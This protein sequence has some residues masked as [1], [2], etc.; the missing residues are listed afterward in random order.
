MVTPRTDLWRSLI[1]NRKT[2]NAFQQGIL[3]SIAADQPAHPELIAADA[4]FSMW[5][6]RV[7]YAELESQG[8]VHSRSEDHE[9]ATGVLL[10]EL[11]E[12]FIPEAPTPE[13]NASI[14]QVTSHVANA[15]RS[16]LQR[17][18]RQAG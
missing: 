17:V 8:W 10:T 9:G 16:M 13:P 3:E 5:R 2:P 11:G 4:G 1:G 14:S 12:S 6:W 18:T 15:A 7:V